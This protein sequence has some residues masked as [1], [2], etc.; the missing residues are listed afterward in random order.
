M[1]EKESGL[2]SGLSPHP[3]PL[4][5]E[6]PRAALKAPFFS[7]CSVN[8]IRGHF[9]LYSSPLSSLQSH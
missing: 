5:L 8:L 9:L 1:Q 6:T 7:H 4:F 3:P 2:S